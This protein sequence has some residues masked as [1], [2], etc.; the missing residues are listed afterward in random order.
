MDEAALNRLADAAGI[1]PRYWD[2]QGHLHERSPETARWLL[3]ALGIPAES[4]AQIIASLKRLAEGPWAE[5]LPPVIVAREGAEIDVPIR[6]PTGGAL[7]A[8]H[9]TIDFETGGHLAGDCGIEAMAVEAQGDVGGTTISLR[10]LKLPAQPPGYHHFRLEAPSEAT[11][12]LIVAP[13]RCYLPAGARTQRYWGVE[14]QLYAVRSKNNWGVGDFGDLRT[15]MGW[16]AAHGAAAVGVNPLHA[17]FLDTPQD[18]SPYSPNSRL[19]LNPL[20]LDITAIPG[21]SDSADIKALVQSPAVSSVIQSARHA[22][23]VDYPA[24]TAIKLSVLEQLHREFKTKRNGNAADR[25]FDKFAEEQGDALRRFAS[26][27]ML[28]ETLGTHDWRQWPEA[29]RNP[30]SQEVVQLVRDNDE[31]VSFFEY[32]QWQC[33][34]QLRAAVDHAHKEG[35]QLGLYR[36]LAISVGAASADHWANQDL[37]LPDARVGAPPDPFN[38][39][40]QEWGVVP[41]NPR[42]LRETGYAH[43]ISLLRANMRYAGALRIDHVMGWKRLFVIPAGASP[44]EGAYLQFPLDDL[45]AIAAL[46]SARNECLVIG[47]DLGTVPAGFR[48]RMAAADILSC[49]ILYFEREHDRFRRPMEL[50]VLAAVSTGTHDLPTVFGYW[51]SEDIAA[52]AHLGLFRSSDEESSARLERANDKRFLLEAL[53]EERLLPSGLDSAHTGSVEWT[54]QLGIAIQAY[55]AR[56]PCLLLLIQLDDL[57]SER[58]QA[59]LPGTKTEFPNWRRRLGRSLEDLA[60]DIGVSE[61]FAAISRERGEPTT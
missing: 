13:P 3:G 4:D 24:V 26:F 20:Y 12:T 43:F 41:L 44:S 49:R 10:R 27:Q 33:H 2:I 47:E 1:E 55:L 51:T 19:F 61:A 59:N 16:S 48:E 5:I 15:L 30:A 56:A 40:G 58:Q 25:R 34:E 45:L 17:L 29:F 35:M 42:R 31:R 11:A 32:L 7:R 53:A 18:A 28:S 6:L 60:V 52:K 50:P 9:W 37:F 22:D 36:D 23:L 38:E 14:A 54:S 46:E 39:N 21:F 8:V 57:T